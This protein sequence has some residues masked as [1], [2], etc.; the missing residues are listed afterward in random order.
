MKNH[1]KVYMK[2]FGYDTSDFIPCELCG[3][4]AADI[5]HIDSRKMGGTK[6]KDVIENLMALCRICV[7]YGDIKEWKH[8][9]IE[10]H[11]LKINGITPKKNWQRAKNNYN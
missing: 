5:H 1:T 7:K 8:Y 11:N 4:R 10:R 9:L 3:N 2:F 6:G